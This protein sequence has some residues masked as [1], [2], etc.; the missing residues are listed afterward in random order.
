M[1]KTKNFLSRVQYCS[2]MR[3][4]HILISLCCLLVV[5]CAFRSASPSITL[6]ERQNGQE[7]AV[8]PGRQIIVKLVSNP[9]T[10][11]AWSVISPDKSNPVL[12]FV[13]EKEIPP[14]APSP[15]GTPSKVAFTFSAEHSGRAKL[16]LVYRRSW[17][18]GV[19]PAND[20]E[21]TIIVIDWQH[22]PQ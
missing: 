15:P 17:E 18:P 8:Y 6:T 7:V 3:N 12:R 5:L 22:P 1:T 21:A 16:H 2:P 20:F 4:T 10:G 13:G 9:S 11:Y 14:T 19:K